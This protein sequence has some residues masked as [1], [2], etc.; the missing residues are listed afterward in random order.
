MTDSPTIKAILSTI[1][2][3]AFIVGVGAFTNAIG[4]NMTQRAAAPAAN[5]YQNVQSETAV[6]THNQPGQT[7]PETGATHNA[8]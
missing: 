3:F 2:T 5:P 7:A 8:P 1:L 4:Q 6:A